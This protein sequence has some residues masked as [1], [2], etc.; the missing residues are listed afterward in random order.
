MDEIRTQRH[1]GT[2]IT[3]EERE[4]LA[5]KV[6]G[7]AIEVHKQLGPGLLESVYE[8]CM[9]DEL[10]RRNIKVRSQISV[11]LFYKGKE[12]NK[13]FKLD[14]LI[15]E[16]LIIELKAV[17]NLIPL[18]EVQLLTYLRLTNKTLG[19]VINFNEVLLKN[20]I[21]RVINGYN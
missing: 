10:L 2:K 9:I 11:P 20:G 12:L 6:I 3:K 1:E 16:E 4:E 21:R 19:L 15:E 7:A 13:E 5:K 18:Y 14:L 17:E 8:H